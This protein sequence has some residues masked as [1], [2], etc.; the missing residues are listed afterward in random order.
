MPTNGN[1]ADSGGFEAEGW[2]MAV[3]LKSSAFGTALFPPTRRGL[4]RGSLP[5]DLPGRETCASPHSQALEGDGSNVAVL[6][7]EHAHDVTP[8]PNKEIGPLP[9]HDFSLIML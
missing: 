3:V 7:G 8:T 1:R 4:G 5:C 9:V 6:G 2:R